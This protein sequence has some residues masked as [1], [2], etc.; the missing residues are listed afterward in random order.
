[1]IKTT[2]YI[3]DASSLTLNP[4]SIKVFSILPRKNKKIGTNKKTKQKRTTTTPT[5]ITKKN[6]QHITY[7]I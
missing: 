7:K 2:N 5:K 3:R 1:L 6:T 4:L